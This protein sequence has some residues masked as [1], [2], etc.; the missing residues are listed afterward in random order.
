G[1]A[2]R[3]A[4][5]RGG[6]LGAT[7]LRREPARSATAEGGAGAKPA[8]SRAGVGD[9]LAAAPDAYGVA[10]T[11]AAGLAVAVGIVV[12][13]FVVAGARPPAGAERRPSDHG[14]RNRLLAVRTHRHRPQRGLGR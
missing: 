11:G 12:F 5:A 1:G 6:P 10:G 7:C 9:H 13:G 2:R 3:A 14:H 4:A 8:R